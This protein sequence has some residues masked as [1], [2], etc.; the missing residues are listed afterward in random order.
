M[1]TELISSQVAEYQSLSEVSEGTQSDLDPPAP[2]QEAQPFT[3][4]LTA[5][6]EAEEKRNIKLAERARRGDY[7]DDLILEQLARNR[8]FLTDEGLSLIHI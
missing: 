2:T 6:E 8:V 5:Q 1:Y 7:D 4:K 3:V